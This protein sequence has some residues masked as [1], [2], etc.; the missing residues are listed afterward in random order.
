[1][2]TLSQKLRL[3]IEWGPAVQLL[4]AIGV[5]PPGQPRV[6]AFV[7][8]LKF[9]STKTETT[10]DDELLA[11]IQ[12]ILLTKEGGALVDYVSNLLNGAAEHALDDQR[13]IGL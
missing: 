13:S 12:A 3:L 10:L 7:R 9:A 11:H 4:T 5:S 8:L 6:L 1:M 2:L